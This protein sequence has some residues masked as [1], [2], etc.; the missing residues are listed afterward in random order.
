M[1][2]RK[3]A[4]LETREK[5]IDAMKLLLQEKSADSINIEDVTIRAGIAKGSFYTHFR[6]KEDV[7]SAIAMERYGMIKENVLRATGGVYEQLCGYLKN[8]ADVIAGNTL[9]IAQNWMR[10]VVA[11]MDG[12]HT[13]MEK[14]RFDYSN[15]TEILGHAVKMGELKEDTPIDI[16][17]EQ[18]INYEFGAVVSWCI[19]E[20]EREVEESMEHF[21]GYGLKEMLEHYQ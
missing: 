6:R 1:G 3:K 11:P 19:T 20:G 12:E 8:S 10:S 4:A 2:K 14:Y 7:I 9:Q 18:I 15:I 16:I 5:I 17:T 21:C 13:G